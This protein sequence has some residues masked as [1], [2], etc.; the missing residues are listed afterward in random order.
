VLIVA[1]ITLAIWLLQVVLT[2]RTVRAVPTL[3][4]LDGAPPKQ[5]PRLSM[6]V[7]ARDEAHGIE[8]ALKS[9]LACGYP[10]LEV[11]AIDD[12]S[13]DQTGAIIDRLAAN[14]PR[15]KAAHIKELPVGWL[16]KLNAMQHGLTAATG[17]WVLFSDADVHIEPGALEK[18][19]AHAEAHA[20]DFIAVF[21]RMHAVSA[22]I[23]AACAGLLR[24]I[25]IT[26]RVW[27]ANDDRSH[28]GIGV[29]A[30]NLARRRVLDSTQAISH[31]RMEVADDISLG[32]LVKQS[33][34]RT[35]F[36]AGRR[37]VH[38]VYMPSIEAMAKSANKA[39]H[40]FGF[41]LIK[42]L[43]M[44]LVPIIG[45]LVVPI[46]ALYAGGITAL[47]GAAILACATFCNTRFCV[48]FAL[49]LRGG[50]LWPLAYPLNSTLTFLAGL[51]AWK[52][53]GVYWRDTFYS[54]KTLEEGRRLDTLT[55]SVKVPKENAP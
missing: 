4:S 44:A 22:F 1:S 36:F 47:I 18:L 27:R 40:L 48:H 42:P 49:P 33:G 51:R 10:Q 9:K 25:L 13:T 21:P 16:G 23:D 29:G 55:F 35:R 6:V 32:A 7:P 15:V 20:I 24:M 12:R 26:G 54:R 31:L 30:F 43:L 14:D 38:L 52:L 41:S 5:W 8:A 19:I 28:I 39:G 2:V 11:V 50:L 45:D 37:Q 34:A 46:A 17:E 53:Q 3:D